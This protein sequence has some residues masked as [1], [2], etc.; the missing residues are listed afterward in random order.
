M[1]IV[2]PNGSGRM[3][4]L[5]YSVPEVSEM[6]GI[7]QKTVYRLLKRGLLSSSN[8]LR[9]KRISRASIDNFVSTTCKGGGR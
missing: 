2:R 9:H 1:H 8:A 4:R 5:F 7:S 6:V 3:E